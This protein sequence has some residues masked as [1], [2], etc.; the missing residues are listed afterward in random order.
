MY[1]YIYIHTYTHT[2]TQVPKREACCWRVLLRRRPKHVGS[3]L[4]LSP[5]GLCQNVHYA[6]GMLPPDPTPQTPAPHLASLNPTP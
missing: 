5:W 1:I 3:P 2:H 4:L 6:E